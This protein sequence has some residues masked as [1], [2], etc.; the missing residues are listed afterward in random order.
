MTYINDLLHYLHNTIVLINAVPG[1]IL[2]SLYLLTIKS[3]Q[4]LYYYC[5]HYT[6]KETDLSKD[7]DLNAL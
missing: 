1:T 2:I 4:Q 3:S 5:L 6:G 7:P